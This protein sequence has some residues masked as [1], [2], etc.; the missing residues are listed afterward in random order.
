[1][2]S[3]LVHIL[4]MQIKFWPKLLTLHINYSVFL[5]KSN[6]PATIQRLQNDKKH[7]AIKKLLF[8]MT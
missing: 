5:K 7:P 3:Q 1:M 8:G 2:S 6:L 4:P